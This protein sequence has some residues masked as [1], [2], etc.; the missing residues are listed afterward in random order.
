MKI[1]R[2]KPCL[3]ALA[4][5]CN[6]L[7]ARALGC[8]TTLQ[9][10]TSNAQIAWRARVEQKNYAETF[11]S[12]GKATKNHTQQQ[13]IHFL[14]ILEEKASLLIILK[15]FS[16]FIRV[17]LKLLRKVRAEQS[18]ND[19]EQ[20][21]RRKRTCCAFLRALTEL[22]HFVV[23]EFAHTHMI[24]ARFARQRALQKIG[25]ENKK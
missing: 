25:A 15:R 20:C 17:F 12:H 18:H 7:N 6:V 3:E 8:I 10:G 19:G 23:R 11:A 2:A 24:L 9:I 4:A 22:S 1:T 14:N 21:M 5:N 13:K 16:F